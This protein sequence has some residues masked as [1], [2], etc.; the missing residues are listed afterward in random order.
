MS[1][2]LY[3]FFNLASASLS[4]TPIVVILSSIEDKILF[5]VSVTKGSTEVMNSLTLLY[6]SPIPIVINSDTLYEFFSEA[7]LN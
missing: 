3:C 1:L 6:L 7:D 5:M 2:I 4:I